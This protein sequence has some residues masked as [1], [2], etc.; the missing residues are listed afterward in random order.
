MIG[1]KEDWLCVVIGL[2]GQ[3][4]VVAGRMETEDDFGAGW[5]FEAHALR[6]DGHAA[7]GAGLEE[8]A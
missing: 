2:S 6:A 8:G 3:D 5:F 7:I 1:E 4:G